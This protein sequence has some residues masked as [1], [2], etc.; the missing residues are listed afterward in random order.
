MWKRT[1]LCLLACLSVGLLQ[2]QGLP[3]GLTPGPAVVGVPYS[4]D[5]ANFFNQFFTQA[6]PG[7]FYSFNLAGGTLPPGLTLAN[8][9]ITGTPTEPGNYSFTAAKDGNPYTITMVGSSPFFN[10]SRTTNIPTVVVPIIVVLPNGSVGP[11]VLGV[12]TPCWI[13]THIGVR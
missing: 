9:E 2:A 11:P 6:P 12:Q 13:T 8:S 1:L 7:F 3:P 4:F 10:G 5:F